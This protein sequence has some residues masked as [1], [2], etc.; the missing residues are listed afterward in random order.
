MTRHAQIIIIIFLAIVLIYI[1]N[2]IRKRQLELKYVLT[3]LTCVIALMVVTCSPSLMGGMA[4][5]LGIQS[6]VNMIFFLG[7][8]F[9]LMI[10]FSLTVALSRVSA[11][12][13]RIAQEL[14]LE[15]EKK[16]SMDDFKT[17]TDTVSE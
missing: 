17:K 16:E 11:K 2:M 1:I 8:I 15:R 13:R 7:F 10:I 12:V 4:R 9:S 5:I 6:P 3:W 14:A